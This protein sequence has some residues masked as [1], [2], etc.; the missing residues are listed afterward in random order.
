LAKLYWRRQ[1]LERMQTG[2][3]R[4]ALQEVE[5]WQHRRE[6]EMANAT[7]DPSHPEMLEIAMAESTDPGV[8]LR[9]ILSSL[10]VIRARVAQDPLSGPAACPI[11]PVA[12]TSACEADGSSPGPQNRG[13][14]LP[15]EDGRAGGT[16]SAIDNQQSSIVN[17]QSTFPAGGTQ[18]AIDNQQSTIVNPQST[19]E[20][21]YR[22]MMGWRVARISR[23]L[24]LFSGADEAGEQQKGEAP[25]AGE[26]ELEELLRLLDEEIAAVQQEFEYA[27]KVNAQ[28]AAIERDACLAPVGETWRMMLRQESALDRSIDRKVKIILSMRKNFFDD[29]LNA[30]TVRT[31][32]GKRK[33]RE[34][35]DI[36]PT[37]G[38]DIP[39]EDPAALAPPE[40]EKS[41]N[42]P[43]MSMKTKGNSPKAGG[44]KMYQPTT[45]LDGDGGNASRDAA[46]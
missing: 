1:R 25:Q 37:L 4:R 30:L 14:T 33:D 23:L 45:N 7:F 11:S 16:Q 32:L 24:R 17:R 6:L 39:Y 26:P 44:D 13:A 43:G 40:L 2:V 42:K 31:N 8:R 41:R 35:E 12:Q 19:L 21:L 9:R 22:G 15:A 5:E 3:M 10:G 28:K 46:A 20:S 27:E 36:D 38:T 34:M 29:S 18:S